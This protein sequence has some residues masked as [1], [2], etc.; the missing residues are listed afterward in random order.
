MRTNEERVTAMHQRAVKYRK[1]IMI[2]NTGI[3]MALLLTIMAGLYIPKVEIGDLGSI[4]DG[5]VA[6]IFNDTN[7]LYLI[8]IAVIA[9]LL[10]VSVTI[11]CFYLKK[12]YES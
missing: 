3:C 4:S 8:V 9:F 2:R 12:W 5:M 11:F 7:I 10:G 1:Y 6:S